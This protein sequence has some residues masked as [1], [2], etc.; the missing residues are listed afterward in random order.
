MGST[1]KDSLMAAM[2]AEDNLGSIKGKQS[3]LFGAVAPT[4]QTPSTPLTVNLEEKISCAISREGVVETAEL[5]GTLIVTPNTEAGQKVVIPIS[6]L[7]KNQWSFGT[8]PKI[9]KSLYE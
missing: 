2:A 5:K 4:K 7:L 8:H 1:R 3:N 6:N 9:N